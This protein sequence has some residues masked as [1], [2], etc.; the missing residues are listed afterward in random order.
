MQAIVPHASPGIPAPTTSAVRPRRLKIT[1]QPKGKSRSG[2]D[3]DG[4]S[5]SSGG[6]YCV[7]TC[8]G[9]YFPLPSQGAAAGDTEACRAACP[10]APMEVYSLGRGDGIEDAVSL[11]GK[12]YSSL[13]TAF[14]YRKQLVQAC[15]CKPKRNRGFASLLRDKTLVS[16]DIV[17]TEKGVYV[18]SGARRFPYR[19]SDFV[20]LS[21]ARGLPRQVKTYLAAIDRLVR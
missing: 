19:E 3:E 5:G 17:V 12:L 10:G 14:S 2:K 9:Y 8:D 13:P 16:G 4:P 7:R 11:K 6:Q 15:S 1:V 20:P 18:F 21:K